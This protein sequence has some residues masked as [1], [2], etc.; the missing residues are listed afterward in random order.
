MKRILAFMLA[1]LMVFTLSPMALASSSADKTACTLYIKDEAGS[2]IAAI[3]CD[4][5]D[6]S[7][8]DDCTFTLPVLNEYKSGYY[9]TF[10]SST[11][12]PGETVKCD[13]YICCFDHDGS[14]DTIKLVGE[15][16]TYSY[17]VILMVNGKIWKTLT[18][19]S[20]DA[21]HM[22]D[23]PTPTAAK[24]NHFEDWRVN[25]LSDRNTYKN[26]ITLNA[27]NSTI[28]LK[29]MFGVCIDMSPCD[30]KC[31]VCGAKMPCITT[32][33]GRLFDWL[34]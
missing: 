12:Q 8:H 11:F 34:F 16:K 14:Y 22:F 19:E 3:T 18:A 25:L 28:T 31:D 29:A 7:N 2:E 23:L 15:K 17:K 30:K 6:L 24:G 5:T 13:D 26:Q 9:Y 20:S 33:I 32:I 21:T 4:C 27:E 10:G 1:M